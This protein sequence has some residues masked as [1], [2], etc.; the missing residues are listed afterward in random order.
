MSMSIFSYPQVFLFIFYAS[1][2]SFSYAAFFFNPY[3]IL[4]VM[5]YLGHVVCSFFFL[6]SSTFSKWKCSTWMILRI[7]ERYVI[8][9]RNLK[10]A[11]LGILVKSHR[12]F[13]FFGKVSHRH[14]F[15]WG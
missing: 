14:F 13:F 6:L 12:H 15:F 8:G 2:F 11:L 1:V 4:V 7:D 10:E 9:I 5:I 3:I